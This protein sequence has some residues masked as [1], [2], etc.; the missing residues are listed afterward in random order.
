MLPNNQHWILIVAAAA[1]EAD[2]VLEAAE[3]AEDTPVPDILELDT[4]VED[5]HHNLYTTHYPYD[6]SQFK[7]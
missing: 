2:T 7:R 3:E 1:V 5:N 6:S 4:P